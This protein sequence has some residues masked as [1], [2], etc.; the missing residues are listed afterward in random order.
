MRSLYA[1]RAGDNHTGTAS[2]SDLLGQVQDAG[3]D[4][5]WYP[6]TDAMIAVVA[7]H[8]P[9]RFDS[10]MDIGAGD[11][12]VLLKLAERCDQEPELY[13]IEKS[14]VLMQAQ[15]ERIT[16]VG[17]DLFEQNLAHLPVDYIF[18]NPP[19]SEFEVWASMIIESSHAKKA[20]LVIPRRWKES[21]EI[22]AA[23]TK[24]GATTRVIHS[25]DFQSGADRRARAIIDIVEV[26][27]PRKD[28]RCY[29]NEIK[30]P[31]DVWF[32]EHISTFDAET[33]GSEYECDRRELVRIRQFDTIREMVD[34]YCEEY[35]RM[36]ENYQA[37]FK[38]DYAL[39]RELGVKKDAVREG[40]KVK[41][42]GLKS[43]YWS[44]L[45]ERLDVITNRL[46]TATRK[47]FL[48]KLT[49]RIPIAF[50]ESNIYAVTLW[51]IKNAN[52]YFKEQL[53]RL[54]RSLSTFDGVL[55][56]KSN[57]R[58]WEK[59]GWRY[60]VEEH[61]HY[62][63]DYRIVVQGFAGIFHSDFG[64]YEYPG[65]LHMSCH[66]MID[67]VIA[68]FYNL[69]FR[70]VGVRSRDRAWSSNCWE[71][72]RLS[73]G[74]VVFQVKAFKNGNRHF[75]FMPDAIKALNIEAGRLLGWLRE[76]K[77]VETEMGYT[78]EDA[79]RFFNGTQFIAP[80]NVKLLGNGFPTIGKEIE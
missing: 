44:L 35:A 68:V 62:A 31:F 7:R 80:S 67:D 37:I 10:L 50:T 36:E 20:F 28:D 23:I 40:I 53:V 33:P 9:E 75:R 51:A 11:G 27:Y 47:K 74:D 15:P 1:V 52:E 60:N 69:G 18:C 22:A 25:D 48:E 65:D 26:S 5:E 54:F 78:T 8:I 59:N 72:W 77:D 6:T 12:R 30:D 70:T 29:S 21:K 63:L 71:D 49:G 34:G 61:S 41:M 4:F 24:R 32:D 46:S 38:L 57:L 17:T 58:T 42:A 39:L 56:Y 14:S 45:F 3:E 79:A 66:E 76:P 43:K 13:A 64:R 2:F 19:Y 73:G 55:N 16:P